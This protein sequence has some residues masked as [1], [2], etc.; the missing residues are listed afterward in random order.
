MKKTISRIIKFHMPRIVAIFV[1]ACLLLTPASAI[2]NMIVTSF[3]LSIISSNITQIE[4]IANTTPSGWDDEANAKY[5]EE[6]SKREELLKSTN[7]NIS[8]FA[9]ANSFKRI[10]MF[11]LNTFA[12]L[13]LAYSVAMLTLVE[14]KN[15]KKL[16]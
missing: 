5:N 11:I 12:F 10:G 2:G 9:N 1:L 14:I 8:D 13:I 3:K 16:K 6:L 7:H 15:I 4:N